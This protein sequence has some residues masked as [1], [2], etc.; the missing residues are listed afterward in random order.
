MVV[1][2][3][4]RMKKIIVFISAFLPLLW[5]GCAKAN[6]SHE[7][8]IETGENMEE[9]LPGGLCAF[10]G[11]EGFGRNAT[12]GRG[13]KVYHVTTLNDGAQIG[14]L[15]YALAQKGT[16]TIVFDVAGTI[17][18]D[19]GLNITNGDLTL[20]GQTAP[21]QGV[22]IAKF[23]VVIKADNVIIRYMR[24][25]VGNEGGG[26]PDG[27]GGM[28]NKNVIV[29]HCSISWSVDECCSIY[30][31]ENLTVQW[32][33]VSESLRSA[34]HGK[35][36]HGY[37]G[38]WGGARVSYHHNL[39]AHHGSR[40]P[41]LGPRAFTQ[42]REYMDMRNNVIYNWG[43]NGCYGGEGMKINIVNNYYKPGPA[44]P[45]N[46][47]IRYRIAG[48][49]IRTS[50]YVKTYPAFAPMKHVW[51]KFY[52]NGNVVEGSEEV[53]KDNWS[54]GVYE[55][56]DNSKNDGLFTELTRDTMRLRVPLETDV[57]TTH[58]AEKAFEL[59]LAYAGCAKQRDIIDDRIVKEAKEGTATYI[60]SITENAASSQGLIDLPSDV[61]PKGATSPWPTLS[62]GNVATDQLKDSDG[63]GMPDVWELKKKLNPNDATDGKTTT[64]SKNGYTNLEVYLNSLVVEITKHLISDYK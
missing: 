44:T 47:A 10:P 40:T 43:G 57:I 9:E 6:D 39:M 19:S 16:R 24:F 42:E 50:E 59:V 55:Q 56:I 28:E 17:F 14:T 7:D 1:N 34:G 46:K 60:G 4:V 31:G 27:L 12:G 53:T 23:P 58:T 32:C 21:G 8:P 45:K 20:A 63:D 15:R 22:C 61:M 18:L 41:R 33:I 37:G 2:Y 48:I 29:D 52:I 25:R 3:N 11:A 38:N 62:D 36:T 54:K 49:G 30:G 51:G 5:E 64:L 13:G 26:E 35:G